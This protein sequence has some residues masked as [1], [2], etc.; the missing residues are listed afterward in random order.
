MDMKVDTSAFW[1]ARANLKKRAETIEA[2]TDFF[3]KRLQRA[4][5]EFDDVNYDRTERAVMSVKKTVRSFSD[6]VDETARH[7]KKLEAL[8]DEYCM[9]GGY[10][11]YGV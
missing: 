10:S 9:N 6:H 7:L 3:I 5:A 11:E 4:H 2:L 8:A 1:N